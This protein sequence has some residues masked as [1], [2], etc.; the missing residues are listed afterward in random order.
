MFDRAGRLL[1]LYDDGGYGPA[2]YDD[3]ARAGL[4]VG[5][6]LL[7]TGSR[8]GW[9]S[10]EVTFELDGDSVVLAEGRSARLGNTGLVVTVVVSRQWIGPPMTDVDLS[11]LAYLVF[12]NE[13]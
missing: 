11:P 9:A 4:T 5:R 6:A 2:Y 1:L 8:D 12:R 7:E 10:L 13:E 3:D